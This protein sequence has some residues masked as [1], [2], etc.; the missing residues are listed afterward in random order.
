MK[1]IARHSCRLLLLLFALA[2]APAAS[3]VARVAPAPLPDFE[4]KALDGRTVRSRQLTT[5]KKWLLIYVE[6]GCRSCDDVFKVFHRE[7]PLGELPQKVAVVVGGRTPEEIKRLAERN[8]WLPQGCWYADPTRRAAA[9]LKRRGSPIVYGIRDGQIE[10]SLDGLVP[11]FEKL[12]SILLT[13]T[14]G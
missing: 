7:T 3:P 13:W 14:E 10:W 5:R 6:P 8:D 9:A 2:L 4:L 11:D 12:E 1:T